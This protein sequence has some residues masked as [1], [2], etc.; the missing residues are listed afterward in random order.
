[1]VTN[2]N[3]NFTNQKTIILELPFSEHIEVVKRTVEYAQGKIPIIA[4]SGANL[5]RSQEFNAQL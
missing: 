5:V 2:S 1:M 4:G 3:F